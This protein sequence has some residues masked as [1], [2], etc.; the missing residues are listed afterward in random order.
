MA[1]SSPRGRCD[2][3]KKSVYIYKS[4]MPGFLFRIE[5]T[6]GAS[7]KGREDDRSSD[8]YGMNLLVRFMVGCWA[9]AF[10]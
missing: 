3:E 2:D 6:T 5:N 9:I 10:E 7:E 8:T 1:E 4:N